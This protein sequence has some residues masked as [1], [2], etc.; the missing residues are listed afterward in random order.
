MNDYQKSF[1]VTKPANRVYTAITEDI[2]KWWSNDLTGAAM[3]VG[4]QFKI[5]FG[6]TRKTF[7]IEKATTN[8]QVIWKCV[9]A[10]IDMPLLKN[11]AEWLGT[12]LIWTLNADGEKTTLTFLHE[13]LNTSFECYAVCEAGWDQ[14]LASLEA[15]LNTGKGKPFLK[16]TGEKIVVVKEKID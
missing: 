15:Y 12:R 6:G 2:S 16:V 4:D 7:E 9:K 3:R 8:E 11:K 1:T 14:F 13:G 10:Y 5:A